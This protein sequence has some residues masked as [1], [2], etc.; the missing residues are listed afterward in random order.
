MEVQQWLLQND[1]QETANLENIRQMK[2]E[3]IA[4]TR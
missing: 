4:K 3:A 2:K 1:L